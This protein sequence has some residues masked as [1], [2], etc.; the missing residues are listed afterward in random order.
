M[1]YV[2]QNPQKHDTAVKPRYKT[3]HIENNLIITTR[4]FTLIDPWCF[5]H[6]EYILLRK[7]LNSPSS[8]DLASMQTTSC[9]GKFWANGMKMLIIQILVLLWGEKKRQLILW[10]TW[11]IFCSSG[12][13]LEPMYSAEGPASDTTL[14]GKAKIMG[15]GCEGT[16]GFSPCGEVKYIYIYF[17]HKE[18]KTYLYI[19]IIPLKS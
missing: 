13:L 17:K 5:A 14:V 15:V 10:N 7:P 3:G 16:V 9:V 6:P 11:K 19:R 4:P 2:D 1:E 18:K 8:K 12:T